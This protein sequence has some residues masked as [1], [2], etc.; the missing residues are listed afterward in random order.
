MYVFIF[1]VALIVMAS[2]IVEGNNIVL[3]I[4]DD[5]D[6]VLDGMIPLQNTRNIIGVHGATYT[7]SFVA[8]P[9]CC[10]NRASILTGK[11]QHNHLTFN[12]SISGGCSNSQW[13][14][15]FE[16]QTFATVLKQQKD[17]NTFYAGK[18][19]NQY[20]TKAA[21][22]SQYYFD[23]FLSINGT[24]KKYGNNTN[25]YLTDVIAEQAVDF[26]NGPRNNAKPFLMVLS[27]PAPHAPF[28]P[29]PRHD[30]KY[31]NI[32]AKK[33]PNFN[34]GPQANKHWLVRMGP[35]PLPQSILPELD[36][37]Y[38]RRWETLLA[39]DE[40]VVKVY[41]ALETKNILNDTYII[42]TSDNGYHIGQFSLPVDKRQP[43]ETDIRV[44]LLIR[45]PGI[46]PSEIIAPVS[47]VDLFATI[48]Q[49]GGAE[50]PSDGVTMLS[51]NISI[52]RTLLIEYRGERSNHP[53]DECPND[54]ANLSQCH[55][56][57]ACKCEDSLN[58]TYACIRRISKDFNNIFCVFEDNEKYIEAYNLSVDPNQMNNIGYTMKHG[59]RHRFR[60]RLKS[61][62]RCHDYKCIRKILPLSSK[63]KI[64]NELNLSSNLRFML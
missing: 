26:I 38:R 28:T 21:G 33:T 62:V 55:K 64:Y 2:A 6:V 51:K 60:K 57:M 32:K 27:P 19:L 49:M 35:S 9:I 15:N 59:Q 20:G 58:N 3:I 36:N 61:M 45:G 42:F 39:V 7:N 52:D 13:Q 44:P 10:P 40:L 41:Q 16:T 4:A 14:K 17:Y 18:Y 46:V 23:Y 24:E 5:L 22:G 12:N 34:T 31:V 54:D 43:Y 30:N 11:Y 37:V 63:L 53:N 48:L 50:M 25:D 8:S 1:M 56:E 47:S 29:A